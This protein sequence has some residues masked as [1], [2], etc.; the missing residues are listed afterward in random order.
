MRDLPHNTQ[1]AGDVFIPNTSAADPMSPGEK[2][3]WLNNN[4]YGYVELAP[5]ADP[6]LVGKKLI[7]LMDRSV[8]LAKLAG[9]RIKVSD[10][11]TPHLTPFGDVHLTSDRYGGITP[12]GNWTM[13]Y[14]FAAIAVLI[15]LVACFN[16]TNLA[17]ARALMRAREISLRKVVGARRGQLMVQFL[18]E[19]VLMALIS[20]I[21]ALALVEILLPFYDRMLGKP[22][23]LHYLSDWSLFVGL[24]VVAILVGLLAAYIRPW[25]FR[26]SGRLRR[27]EPTPPDNQGSGLL[28][29]ALVVM[30]FAVSIGLGIVALVVFAQISFAQAADWD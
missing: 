19:S 20:L 17:T 7:S 27:F 3:A 8:D 30:Q 24:L 16:F 5:G 23:H 1:I 28:R 6:E 26:A 15:L 29:T 4:G 14:G 22:I 9:T 25:C 18:G 10:M 2:Q 13:V 11:I 12:G 21:L